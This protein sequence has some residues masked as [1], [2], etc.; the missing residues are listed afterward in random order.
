[1]FLLFIQLHEK[2]KEVIPIYLV[3]LKKYVRLIIMIVF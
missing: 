3:V 1:M 2:E